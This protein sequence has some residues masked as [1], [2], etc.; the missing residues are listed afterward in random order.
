LAITTVAT[1]LDPT[2]EPT[3][4]LVTPLAVAEAFS[5][6]LTALVFDAEPP[7][8]ADPAAE[9]RTIAAV[10]AAA[11]RRGVACEV[12]GRS[13][14]AFGTGE[15]LADHLRVSD[16]GVLTCSATPAAGHRF[17]IGSA[18]FAT[19]RPILLVPAAAPLAAPPRR[20]VVGW[21]ASPAAVRAV[22]GA[23][24]FITRAEATLVIS[25][26]NDKDVRSGQSGIELTRLLAR[27]GAQAEFRTVPR[28]GSVLAS[29][30]AAAPDAGASLLVIGAVR[31][32]PVRDLVFGGATR[33]L[34]E[35][36]PPVPT[37][38]AA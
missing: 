20:I 24:P 18:I 32:A 38:L 33:D 35:R 30:A 21:D 14:F 28:Q 9:E 25:V 1:H 2:A 37:L 7:A 8:S 19:G 10:R 6:H 29:L 26:T 34:L 17:L 27:H 22:H 4:S 13:S 12:R 3:A 5:A 31:H 36:G 11:E 15:V 16:I 23:L